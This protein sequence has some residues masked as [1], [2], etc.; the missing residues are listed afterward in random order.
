MRLIGSYMFPS[1]VAVR[2]VFTLIGTEIIERWLAV[3]KGTAIVILI[4]YGT[5]I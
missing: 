1:E 4:V 5:W 2:N 3:T